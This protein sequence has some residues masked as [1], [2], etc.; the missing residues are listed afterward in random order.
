MSIFKK[1]MFALM[2]FLFAGS[3]SLQAQEQLTDQE[4]LALYE[5]LRVADVSDGMDKAGLWDVGLMD[6][7]IIS[8]WRDFEDL[9]HLMVGIALTVRYVPA[10][11][12]LPGKLSEEEFDK[13]VGKW[14]N[15][16]SPEPFADS[17]KEGHVIVID[18]QG[19][20]DTG[21]V[22]SFNSLAWVKKG[23]RGIVTNGSVRDTDEIAK[24]KIPCYIDWENRGRGI[25][26][27]RNEFESM[28]QTI[29]VGGVQINPGDVIVADGDG[30][31]VVPREYAR[32][33][34]DYAHKTLTGDK[35]N[36]RRLYEQLGI[37]MD[38]TVK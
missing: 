27:G 8:M 22:G 1:S 14:Y 36:R 29:A 23:A 38:K 16:L 5:G 2:L 24:Q 13:W 10:N 25:R 6:Q 12:P 17:I 19:D 31:I 7:K 15:E 30:V 3:Y 9:S 28:N 26:P 35:A 34:A 4:I 20:G 32:E 21:S 33:V 11:D 18:A 37:D